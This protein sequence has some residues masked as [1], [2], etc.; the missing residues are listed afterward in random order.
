MWRF[1]NNFGSI[2]EN[3]QILF[4]QYFRFLAHQLGK[5]VSAVLS[6][7]QSES[8]L[9]GQSNSPLTTR[10]HGPPMTRIK[11]YIPPTKEYDYE[12]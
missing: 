8:K 4:V 2:C 3:C 12:K 7:L 5:P 10:F 1:Q 11:Y 9:T 6:L